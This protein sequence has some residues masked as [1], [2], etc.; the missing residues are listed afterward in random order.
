MEATSWQP[1]EL[2]QCWCPVCRREFVEER[3][4]EERQEW[5]VRNCIPCSVQQLFTL[6][7]RRDS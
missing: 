5:V 2:V 1:E 3:R 6:L 7:K 4:P